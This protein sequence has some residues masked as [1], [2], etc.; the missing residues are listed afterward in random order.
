[1]SALV[2]NKVI[3]KKKRMRKAKLRPRT[4]NAVK[5]IVRAEMAPLVEK[6]HFDTAFTSQA[7]D[8]TFS[9]FFD[10]SNIPQGTADTQRIGDKIYLESIQFK[11]MLQSPDNW[12]YTRVQL[13]QW[14]E[15]T[16]VANVSMGTTLQSATTI[17]RDLCS[18]IQIDKG[19]KFKI[20]YDKL[21]SQVLSAETQDV[22][23]SLFKNKGFKRVIEYGNSVTS[24]MSH[25][26]LLVCSN[27]AL[28]PHPTIDGWARLR[29]R[30][31]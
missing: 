18:P 4:A 5:A 27:S 20:L 22:S 6:K 25:I 2:T 3:S 7:I 1:M 12:S 31:A 23:F 11:F 8:G 26:F 19:S 13:V 16:A 17:P 15:D 28:V 24:G 14:N 29:Y 30:D 9:Q 10:L 21:F